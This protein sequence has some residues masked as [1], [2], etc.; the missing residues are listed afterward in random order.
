MSHYYTRWCY[1]HGDWDQDVDRPYEACPTCTEQGIAP[2]QVKAAY[3]ARLEEALRL[4]AGGHIPLDFSLEP[5]GFHE[6]IWVW[7]QQIAKAALG[8]QS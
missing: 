2:S 5:A 1:K 3:V 7:S 6:R 8:A 4:I